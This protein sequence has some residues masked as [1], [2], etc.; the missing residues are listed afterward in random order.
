MHSRR[1]KHFWLLITG[2]CIGSALTKLLHDHW[3]AYHEPNTNGT[4][5]SYG[6]QRQGHASADVAMVVASQSGDDTS[7]LDFF[8]DWPKHIYVTDDPSSN[9]TVPANKGREGMAYLT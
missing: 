8:V 7:W 4:A 1:L 9:L 3:T 5:P 6:S 2:L